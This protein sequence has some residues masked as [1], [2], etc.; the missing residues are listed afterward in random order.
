MAI[1]QEEGIGIREV[2]QEAQKKEPAMK[3]TW[4]G[5]RIGRR[6]MKKP[7]FRRALSF[8]SNPNRGRGTFGM[9]WQQR[10]ALDG[11]CGGA[12]PGTGGPAGLRRGPLTQ[13]IQ[14]QRTAA[15][16]PR[17]PRTCATCNRR[18]HQN[19]TPSSPLPV[20]DFPKM[21]PKV[22]FWPSRRWLPLGARETHSRC[23]RA[24]DP[25]SNLLKYRERKSAE[26]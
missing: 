5:R 26:I 13:A 17:G 15:A 1:R 19:Y 6:R 25:D 14:G 20:L 4:P 24:A 12:T 9:I 23:P 3:K 2:K 8:R 10:Q 11:S 7:A 21:N 22:T 16:V 18:C